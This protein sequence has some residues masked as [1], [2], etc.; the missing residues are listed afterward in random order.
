METVHQ[1]PAMQSQDFKEGFLVGLLVGEAHFGGDGRQP[2]VTI[3]MHVRHSSLFAWLQS[4][5]P[6]GKLY[7]PY[8]HQGRHYYQWMA[9]GRYL[10]DTLLP[11][12]ERWL[13]PELDLKTYM[14]VQAMK[15]RYP[16]RLDPGTSPPVTDLSEPSPGLDA[17]ARG[18]EAGASPQLSG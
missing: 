5:F 18:D 7:G 17:G 6:G 15:Q 16:V 1:N 4:N 2:Q 13:T 14:A 11:A 12:V 3:K 9:R 8:H 10:R